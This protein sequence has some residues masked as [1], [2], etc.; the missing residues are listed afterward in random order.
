MEE[1]EYVYGLIINQFLYL[2]AIYPLQIFK[3]HY[4]YGLPVN[5]SIY[6]PL[7]HYIDIALQKVKA[8]L[9]EI[10]LNAVELRLYKNKA[11]C[12]RFFLNIN[13]Q[14][15]IEESE[16]RLFLQTLNNRCKKLEKLPECCFK[17]LL[18]KSRYLEQTNSD[19]PKEQV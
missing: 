18:H 9:E 13:E 6:P 4:V 19:E 15:I 5:I 1:I 8:L 7:N 14:D 16:L 17:I 3:K 2:R 10:N 11:I 12:E